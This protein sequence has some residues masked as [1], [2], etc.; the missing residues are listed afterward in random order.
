MRR[1]S[2]IARRCWMIAEALM[3]HCT[4]DAAMIDAII[5]RA[6]ECARRADLLNVIK[7]AA[8]FAA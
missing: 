6:P 2:S 8:R 7:S 4:L 5:S 3:V 1:P